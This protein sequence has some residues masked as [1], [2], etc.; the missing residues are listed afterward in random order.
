MIFKNFFQY[1]FSRVPFCVYCRLSR[2]KKLFTKP[3]KLNV[4]FLESNSV[5]F[6]YSGVLA[7]GEVVLYFINNVPPLTGNYNITVPGE[8]AF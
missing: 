1:I 2:H 4:I 5:I 6:V 3:S 7:I 8:G